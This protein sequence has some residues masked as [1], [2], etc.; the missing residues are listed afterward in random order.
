MGIQLAVSLVHII[1]ERC[2]HRG[3]IF[4]YLDVEG[5]RSLLHHQMFLVMLV[6]ISSRER[7]VRVWG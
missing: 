7:M 4:R 6:S 2:S 1:P 3:I 5:I